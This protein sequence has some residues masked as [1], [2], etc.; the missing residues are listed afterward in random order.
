MPKV[1]DA[2]ATAA[3]MSADDMIK[4][5]T[6]G[7]GQD[8]DGY[9]KTFCV[10]QI[11]GLVDFYRGLGEVARARHAGFPFIVLFCLVAAALVALFIEA[12]ASRPATRSREGKMLAFIA[13]LRAARSWSPPGPV[14]SGTNGPRSNPPNSASSCHV[15]EGFGRSLYIDDPSYVPAAHF[16]NNRIPRD[17]ACYTC[18]TEYT[19]FGPVKSKLRGGLR[20]LYVQYIV[21]APK[22]ESIKL[23]DPFQKSRKVSSLPPGRAR[24]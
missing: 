10:D 4:I 2:H 5:V 15:M 16:Q 3:K 21:G 11:K 1:Q 22:P 19:L 20:H 7:K 9:G 23:Y 8:M 13:P 17:Q 12:C 6:D 24:V 14:S 18:H